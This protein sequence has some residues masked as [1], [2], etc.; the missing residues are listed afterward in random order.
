MATRIESWFNQ[1][2]TEPVKVQYLNGNVFSQDNGGN[3]VGVNIFNNGEPYNFSGSA[4]ANVVRSDGA[5]VAVTGTVEGN[6]AY[7]ILPQA[8]Y[9]IPGQINIIIK[10]SDSGVITTLCAVVANVYQSSTDT[11][12]DPGTIIPSID[13]LIAEIE[14]AVA[15]IP[16]DYSSLD[17][18]VKTLGLLFDDVNKFKHVH[19]TNGAYRYYGSG[20]I[21]SNSS[22]SYSDYVVITPGAYCTIQ[23]TSN[24]HITF[25]NEA[26][27]YISGSLSTSFVIP[28]NA[29]YMVVSI[30]IADQWSVV[31]KWTDNRITVKQTIIT[32]ATSF[33][34]FNSAEWNKIYSFNMYQES[35]WASINHAPAKTNGTLFTIDTNEAHYAA[36]QI[37]ISTD[38]GIYVRF[39]LPGSS[40][41][42]SWRSSLSVS[43]PSFINDASSISDFNDAV[44]NRWY[45]F[46]LNNEYWASIDN[47]PIA[48]N[49]TLITFDTN[50]AHYAARQIY[51]TNSGAIYVRFYIPAT[52]SFTAWDS[53]ITSASKKVGVLYNEFLNSSKAAEFAGTFTASSDGF[54]ITTNAIL[55]RFYSIDNRTCAYLCKV[56]SDSVVSF[57]T[58]P[59]TN[60]QTSNA[61]LVVN[62]PNGTVKLNDFPTE[63]CSFLAGGHFISV[64]LSKRYQKFG[65]KITDMN[66]GDTFE[67]EYIN[68][69]AGGAGEGA[70]STPNNVPMQYDYYGCQKVSGTAVL[71][72]KMTVKCDVADVVCYGDSVTEQEAYYPTN[73]FDKAW[74]Q[75]LISESSQKVVT[76][77]RGGSNVNQIIS[78]IR[79]ELPYLNAKY[80]MVTIGTNAGD[81]VEN[82]TE[83][84]EYIKSCGVIPILNHI[85]CYNNNG[86]STSFKNVNQIID[87]V[88]SN[89][90]VKGCNF[91]LCT[92]VDY[93]GQTLNPDMMF[94]ETYSGGSV[95]RHHP[96]VLG[97]AAMLAQ[98]RL[99]VPE[100]F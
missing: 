74:T 84:V 76:S 86:D 15:S 92:S 91:D 32:D 13:A 5:T 22:Y 45:T 8:A 12:V 11:A 1:D 97:S 70:I 26:Y 52:S 89:T 51:I 78:R 53:Q 96:N 59:Y 23:N 9:A 72:K 30:P 85:P 95:Y 93:D 2:L 62:I 37:Y 69:G 75:L 68:N 83:V 17:G 63:I 20:E 43:N 49:G 98:L 90:G 18:Q 21:R 48:E 46:N 60:V 99:D 64:E 56:F 77:G 24:P 25:Y 19:Y 47:K 81:T 61:S 40:S 39:Y 10:L 36:R 100:L 38:G 55:G 94:L 33:S 28:S 3:I 67:K 71:L 14:A 35:S 80:C 27:T 31:V 41:F 88:R 73:I 7:I 54:T 6:K 44:W 57:Y 79:N 87:T 34:D 50:D 58:A 4:S 42:S 29:V 16:S 82:L 66:T 65:I